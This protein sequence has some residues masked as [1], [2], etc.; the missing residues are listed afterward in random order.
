MKRDKEKT[1]YMGGTSGRDVTR[2]GGRDGRRG[3]GRRGGG[4]GGGKGT[5]GKKI[6]IVNNY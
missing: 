1:G 5:N 2:S 4:R 6:Y 3:T